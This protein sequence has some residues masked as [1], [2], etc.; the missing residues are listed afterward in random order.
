[1]MPAEMIEEG[2]LIVTIAGR[3]VPINTHNMAHYDECVA[4]CQANQLGDEAFLNKYCRDGRLC[5]GVGGGDLDEHS[6]EGGNLKDE[7]ECCATLTAKIL[8][9]D[10]KR[11]WRNILR[12][13]QI[14]DRKGSQHPRD[15]A[16]VLNNLHRQ[17]ND[18]D[19][20][21]ENINWAMQGTLV[22]LHDWRNRDFTIE[23][24][25]KVAKE[26]IGEKKITVED[27]DPDTWLEKGE[28]ALRVHQEY[29]ENALAEFRE[30]FASRNLWAAKVKFGARELPIVAI[31][32]NN[33]RMGAALRSGEGV[34]TA[35]IIQKSEKEKICSPEYSGDLISISTNKQYD[36]QLEEVAAI[37]R[38]EEQVKKGEMITDDWRYLRS[39]GEVV[40]AEEW[41]FDKKM[42]MLCNGS[43]THPE[44][45]PTKLSFRK[46]FE[47][48]H[49]GVDTNLFRPFHEEKCISGKC[50]KNECLWHPWGLYR[51]RDIRRANYRKV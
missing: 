7:N 43:L 36:L 49:I 39:K 38:Y 33:Y 16:T 30:K 26:L 22:K 51:C 11:E 9:L 29:F 19:A 12:F 6:R 24:I 21:V 4:A 2:E 48:T 10:K 1:M 28:T 13:T 5:L 32:S 34:S 23:H 41:Y 14:N 25:A 47:Y 35:V 27:I 44:V 50:I 17:N 31:E 8:G 46:V 37:I 40:G 45:P 18:P 3:E 15:I 20:Q 42:Q